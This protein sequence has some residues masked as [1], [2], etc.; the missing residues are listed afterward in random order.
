MKYL[1]RGQK[2]RHD[3]DIQIWRAIVD[4]LC[5]PS[6][7]WIKGDNVI[8]KKSLMNTYFP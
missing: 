4:V 1:T 8:K 5:H 2:E 6:V 7:R 3:T